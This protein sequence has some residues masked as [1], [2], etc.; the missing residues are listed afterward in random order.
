MIIIDT[1]IWIPALRNRTSPEKAE[2]ERLIFEDAAAVVGIVL[3]EV[4]RG[5]RD[6]SHFDELYDQMRGAFLIED[7]EGSWLRAAEL[8]LDLK[9]RGEVIPLPDAIIAAQALLGSHAVYTADPH[10]GRIAGLRLHATSQ[11]G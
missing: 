11:Q 9:L 6:R 5:A 7:D 8:L 10:F 4:L 3:V 1:S 2:V